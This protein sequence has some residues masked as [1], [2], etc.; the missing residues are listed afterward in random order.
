M[1][2]R[3]GI[4][5][6]TTNTVVSIAANGAPAQLGYFTSIDLD[7]DETMPGQAAPSPSRPQ[8]PAPTA[9][10]PRCRVEPSNRKHTSAAGVLSLART[11][12]PQPPEPGPPLTQPH[13]AGGGPGGPGDYPPGPAGD[14]S[15]GS[16]SKLISIIATAVVLVGVA[17]GVGFPDLRAR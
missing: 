15:G 14:G 6:G 9:G 11:V 8:A 1:A 4:D 16:G 17:V 12:R 5:H 2:Y 3:L 10:S 7:A 13:G